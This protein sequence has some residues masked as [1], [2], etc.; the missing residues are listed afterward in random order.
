MPNHGNKGILAG[1]PPQ[2]AREFV[3]FFAHLGLERK[4]IGCT[5]RLEGK[6]Q[7]DLV[8]LSD[9]AACSP[10]APMSPAPFF[11]R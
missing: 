8:P 11:G 9:V 10:P 7:S 6:H 2:R 5:L 3:L 1:F 4:K